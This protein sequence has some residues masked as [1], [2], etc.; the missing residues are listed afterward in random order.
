MNLPEKGLILWGENDPFVGMD[1]ADRFT[2][3]WGCPLHVMKD[4]G[5]W[6]IIERPEESAEQI[7]TF[8]QTL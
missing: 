1:V 8:W 4:T 6:G 2:A 3:R 7:K 5:H